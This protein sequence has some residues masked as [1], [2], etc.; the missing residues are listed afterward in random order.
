MTSFFSRNLIAWYRLNKRDLPWRSTN[1]PYLIWLSEVILQQ[2]QVSQGLPY[3]LAF[4]ARFPDVRSLAQAEEDEVMKLWQGLGYYSRARNMHAAAKFISE[5][6]KG[7]FPSTFQG[8]R[9]LK[10]VGDYTAAAIASIA[11]GLPHAVVD[12]NVYRVL[13]RFFGVYTAIDTP[14]GRSEFAQLAHSQLNINEPSR[15]NQAVMELGA[16]VC[17]PVAPACEECPLKQ[18]CVAFKTGSVAA[19]PVKQKKVK[20]RNRHFNYLVMADSSGKVHVEKREGRDIWQGLYQ[21]RLLETEN[22]VNPDQFLKRKEVYEECGDRFTVKHVSEPYTHILTH[23]RLHARFYVIESRTSRPR[24]GVRPDE[25]DRLA[26][27][28]LISRFLEDCDLKEM[29]YF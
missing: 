10:G 19:L 12:G 8:L 20:T 14:A 13:S 15:H 11:F 26:F 4:T 6:L 21:F 1:D 29:F 22:A 28:R 2:T 7:A 25:L 9:S 5:E 3:Y 16:L 27:P 24:G 18:K 23:Q 17:R